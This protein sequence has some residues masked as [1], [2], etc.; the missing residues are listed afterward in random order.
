MIVIMCYPLLIYVCNETIDIRI[1]DIVECYKH[2][3]I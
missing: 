2:N 3:A 1:Y